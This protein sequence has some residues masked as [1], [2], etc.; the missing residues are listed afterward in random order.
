M[1]CFLTTRKNVCLNSKVSTKF[2]IYLLIFEK[3]FFENYSKIGKIKQ[4]KKLVSW[5]RFFK[6]KFQ[7][8]TPEIKKRKENRITIVWSYFT[9]LCNN[10]ASVKQPT[11]YT[12]TN[13]HCAKSAQIKS[14]F[15]SVFFFCCSFLFIF[16]LLTWFYVLRKY[17]KLGSCLQSFRKYKQLGSCLQPFSGIDSGINPEH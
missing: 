7:R 15:W 2:P 17:K 16:W 3:Q 5:R 13:E 4:L 1:K 14:F 12:M 11:K 8:P 9:V 10:F 6:S